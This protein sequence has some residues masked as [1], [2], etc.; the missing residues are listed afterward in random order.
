M[1]GVLAGGML[2]APIAFSASSPGSYAPARALRVTRGPQPSRHGPVVWG[3]TM[4]RPIRLLWCCLFLVALTWPN[5]AVARKRAPVRYNVQIRKPERQYIHVS[6][7]VPAN[8]RRTTTVA[9][10]AW[11]PG[12]YLIRD[13]AKHVYDVE[14]TDLS[15]QPLALERK[16]K[17]TWTIANRRRGFV[18]KYRVFAAENSVRTTHVDDTHATLR[19]ASVFMYVIGDEQRPVE[20]AIVAP[21]GWQAYSSLHRQ[22]S[23]ADVEYT[24]PDFDTLVDSP[25]ELGTPVVR[26]FHHGDAE[27]TYVFTAPSGSNADVDR[28]VADTKRIVDALATIMGGLP[29]REYVFL[30]RA[31]NGGG[32]GGLEHMNSC[33]I[34]IDANRFTSDRAYTDMARL[35]AHEFFHLWNVK[36]LHDRAL[37]PFDY[38][39]ENHSRLLWFH[40]G[41]TVTMANLALLRSGLHT[42]QQH[43]KSLARGWS[44]YQRKPGRNASPISETSFEAWVKL[45]KP[46]PNHQNDVIS[47]YDKGN[48]IGVALDLELRKR[49]QANGRRGSLEG[50]FRRLMESHGARGRGIVFTDIVDAAAAEAGEPMAWFF[51]RF[52]D[53]Q[54]PLPIPKLLAD[55]GVLVQTRSASEPERDGRRDDRRP[56]E[57]ALKLA[58]Q[59]TYSGLTLRKTTVS[60]VAPASPGARAGVMRGDEIVAVAG[61]RTNDDTAITERLADVGVGGQTQVLVARGGRMMTIDITLSASP[62]SVFNFRLSPKTKLT[63]AVKRRRSAWLRS[64]QENG[65][66]THLPSVGRQPTPQQKR[67]QPRGRHPN[68]E[69]RQHSSEAKHVAS[70]RVDHDKAAEHS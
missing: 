56:S 3:A 23:S 24:A 16:D 58:R 46:A 12:S 42:P 22:P 43:L 10:P 27:L 48:W 36:R 68:H 26:T 15:G 59:Q 65:R 21:Q 69:I 38:A 57:D 70:N 61:Q 67:H 2:L 11:T 19:G 51:A 60:N 29:F 63:K 33:D 62:H 14:V 45:Y 28:L 5:P 35:M 49:S 32:G 18:V 31:N 54:D 53:G 8:R 4:P 34:I 17:Q 30:V 6:M 25:I 9:M 13:F 41:F 50:L 1:I 52:V 39:R 7:H 55:F 20:V 47:Y 66:R 64:P 37:G 44:R 40:E